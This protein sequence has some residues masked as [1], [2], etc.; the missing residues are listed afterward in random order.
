VN[1][2][3]VIFPLAG[4]TEGM[5]YRLDNIEWKASLPDADL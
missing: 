3:L 1:T 4:Q 2:G 5:V